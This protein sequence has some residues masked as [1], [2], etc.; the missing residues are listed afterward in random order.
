[1]LLSGHDQRCLAENLKHLRFYRPV[2]F[3]LEQFGYRGAGD[4]HKIHVSP[5]RSTVRTIGLPQYAFDAIPVDRGAQ[6]LGNR[7]PYARPER[8]LGRPG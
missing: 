6:S 3:G 8:G 7:E 2:A 1:M 5:Q 4:Q